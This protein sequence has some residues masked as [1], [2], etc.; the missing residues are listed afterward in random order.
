MS[1]FCHVTL[2]VACGWGAATRAADFYVDA[3]RPDDS[4]DGL[5]WSTAKRTIQ[6][7]AD[8]ALAGETVWVAGGVYAPV[9][10]DNKAVTIRSVDGA[11]ATAIDGGWVNRCATLGSNTVLAGFTLRNGRAESGGGAIG[12]TLNN[13]TLSGNTAWRFGGGAWESILNACVLTGNAAGNDGGGAWESTLNNCVLTGNTAKWCGGG[14]WESTLN[15]CTLAGNTAGYYGG[16]PDGGGSYGGTLNNCVVWGNALSDGDSNNYF[17]GAF[18]HSCA[19]PLPPGPGNTAADPLFAD[20]PGGD[21]RLRAGSPCIDAGTNAYAAGGSDIDGNARIQGGT[22][23]MGAHEGALGSPGDFIVAVRVSGRGSVAPARAAA[24]A[25]G[26]SLSFV[27][28]PGEAAF[29]GFLTN[30]VFATDSPAFTWADIAADGTLTAVFERFT[31]HADASRPDDSGDGLTWATAKRTIQAAVDLAASG[32]T[33]RV[34][35]GVYAPE[36]GR[37]HV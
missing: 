17:G 31:F 29:L 5:T 8:L 19:A 10:T 9:T 4:G 1:K 11:A 27:A 13:C 28:L 2:A 30:G 36:I 16:G 12:G 26:G 14:A 22:V 34:A 32:E 35:D 37:A 23:D 25:P 15:N 6:A 3:A 7:A 21:F 18:L 33:V 24:T 20:A